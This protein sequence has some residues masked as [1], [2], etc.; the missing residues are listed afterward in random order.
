M[1]APDINDADDIELVNAT[2]NGEETDAVTVDRWTNSGKDRVYLNGLDVGDG[3]ISLINGTVDGDRWTKVTGEWSRDEELLTVRIGHES[4]VSEDPA[5]VITLRATGAAFDEYYGDDESTAEQDETDD[6]DSLS[7]ATEC[8]DDTPTVMADGGEDTPTRS[9]L[10][11][12]GADRGLDYLDTS[13]V[14]GERSIVLCNRDAPTEHSEA[15]EYLVC[16]AYHLGGGGYMVCDGHGQERGY[17]VT[18][19]VASYD[20]IDEAFDAAERLFEDGGGV[21]VEDSGVEVDGGEVA[22]E[23]DDGYHN[24]AWDYEIVAGDEL[25]VTLDYQD[26]GP[27]V[28]GTMTAAEDLT[29]AEGLAATDSN[30]RTHTIWFRKGDGVSADGGEGVA[31]IKTEDGSRVRILRMEVA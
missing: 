28:N 1:K 22:E 5:Y 9:D 15:G 27:T 26:G 23:G 25:Q 29:A 8:D 19:S 12:A 16:V 6:D 31:Y 7:A 11:D 30:G 13:D 21:E 10:M 24:T 20:T 17:D 18:N 3:Y 4:D 14:A 2:H